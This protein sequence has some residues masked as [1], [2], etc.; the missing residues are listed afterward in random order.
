MKKSEES[1]MDLWDIMRQNNIH[2]MEIPEEGKKG[3]S[4]F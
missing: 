1:L 4:V 3:Q 2:I